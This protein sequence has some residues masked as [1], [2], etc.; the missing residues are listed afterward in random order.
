MG[1]GT[2]R[3]AFCRERRKT[4]MRTTAV[5]AALAQ[6]VFPFAIALQATPAAAG[7]RTP[8]CH[9]RRNPAPLKTLLLPRF[10]AEAHLRHGDAVGVCI[11]PPPFA[12][13]RTL[14]EQLVLA[15]RDLYE[16]Q[17]AEADSKFVDGLFAEDR[18]YGDGANP[19]TLDSIAE[20][21]QSRME[22]QPVL[23]FAWALSRLV[24]DPAAGVRINER[25]AGAGGYARAPWERDRPAV[26]MTPQRPMLVASVTKVMAAAAVIRLLTVFQ[27]DLD[28]PFLDVL[29][30][31][32]EADNTL[33]FFISRWRLPSIQFP[34]FQ[35]QGLGATAN[36]DVTIRHLLTHTSGYRDD[37]YGC[38]FFDLVRQFSDGPVTPPGT[39][40]EYG[41]INYCILELLVEA[42]LA[43]L[44]EYGLFELY[45]ERE[46]FASAGL[47]DG[48]CAGTS[49]LERRPP[50]TLFYNATDLVSGNRRAGLLGPVTPESTA[51][52]AVP[53]SPPKSW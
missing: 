4:I 47:P 27:I 40:H 8:V 38:G 9:S 43:E 17:S 19:P 14:E 35:P 16:R 13:A 1:K 5:L 49:R 2:G 39:I 20:C 34:F 26:P 33:L 37:N 42:L 41:N 21:V 24:I 28:R 53:S 50:P 7:Q 6:L 10:A 48:F 45:L 31:L 25:R 51:R 52:R 15:F 22:A 44:D 3:Y 12:A 30:D 46:V 18:I 29:R 23:G 32:R 36:D 11:D